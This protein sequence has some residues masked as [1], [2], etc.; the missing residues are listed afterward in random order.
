MGFNNAKTSGV[1]AEQ[2]V[3]TVPSGKTGTIIGMSIANV[4]S[5]TIKVSVKLGTTYMVKDA[6]IPVGTSLV[7]V[8]GDQKVVATAGEAIKVSS[9]TASSADVI[10]SMLEQ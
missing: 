3:Y 2:T 6:S 9:N 10:V 7:V 8:G 4:A 1:G 5:A